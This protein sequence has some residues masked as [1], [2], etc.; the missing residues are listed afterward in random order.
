M[1]VT[2][3]WLCLSVKIKLGGLGPKSCNF[4]EIWH[5]DKTYADFDKNK[6]ENY[7]V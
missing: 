4:L 6:W 1:A 7:L 2:L 3:A 5:E